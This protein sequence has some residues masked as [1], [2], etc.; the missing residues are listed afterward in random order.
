VS[1]RC[2]N[3]VDDALSDYMLIRYE[4]FKRFENGDMMGSCADIRNA[5]RDA[6]QLYI[7][8]RNQQEAR[9]L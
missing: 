9:K 7:M 6:V 2:Q 3:A 1:I 8:H 5:V 4:V